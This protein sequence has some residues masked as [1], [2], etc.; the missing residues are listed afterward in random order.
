MASRASISQVW[1]S[2][3]AANMCIISSV[4]MLVPVRV[5]DESE[6]VVWVHLDMVSLLGGRMI[7]DE[8]GV[9]G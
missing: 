5:D 7:G 9:G 8:G 4:V 3:S 6:A 2:S 1:F